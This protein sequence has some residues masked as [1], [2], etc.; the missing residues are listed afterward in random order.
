MN[1][2][3]PDVQAFMRDL[4]LEVAQNY[5]VDGIQ[6]DDRLPAF[7][8]EGFDQDA[9]DRFKAKHGK[10]PTGAKDEKW[11][12]FRAHILTQFLKELCEQVRQV[13]ESKGKKLLIS[14]A[15]HPR[16]FGFREALQDT[17]AWFDLV[18]MMHPQLYREKFDS[19]KDLVTAEIGGLSPTQ[20]AKISPGIL[21]KFGNYRIEA[22]HLKKAIKINRS[23]DF[24]GE[25]FFFFE[26]LR[27]PDDSRAKELR[28]PHYAVIKRDDEG[29]D[30][31]KLQKLLIAKGFELREPDGIFGTKTE[32]AVK[33]FQQSHSSALQ[34]DGKVGQ[35][36]LEK[37]GISDL[38]AFGDLIV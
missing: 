6:G 24:A 15:P 10:F 9:A 17:K 12:Q 8:V 34:V 22:D 27:N 26:G 25:S 18:D 2:L 19:Y 1:A 5:D 29:P 31:F 37:L 21:M 32:E 20:R 35:K 30:V 13:G 4:I 23:T 38:Q 36:T 11:M 16:G 14:M 33:K 3:N 28:N 7:P